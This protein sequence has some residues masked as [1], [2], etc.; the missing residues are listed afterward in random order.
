MSN[1]VPVDQWLRVSEAARRLGLS[2]D[3]VRAWVRS[4]KLRAVKT[5]YGRLIDP[6]SVDHAIEAA[7]R[8]GRALNRPRM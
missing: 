7:Y 2:A 3:T 4:G 8:E 6:V 5:S 1:R